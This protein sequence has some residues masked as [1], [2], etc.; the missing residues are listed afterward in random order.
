MTRFC[1]ACF[2]VGVTGSVGGNDGMSMSMTIE[3]LLLRWKNGRLLIVDDEGESCE[4]PDEG[5][6]LSSVG[7]GAWFVWRPVRRS[8]DQVVVRSRA[9]AWQPDEGE[10]WR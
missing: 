4:K 8:N 1:T 5:A 7:V 10:T 9:K 3:D 6:S 2:S